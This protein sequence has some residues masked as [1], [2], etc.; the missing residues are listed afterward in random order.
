MR[1]PV[2]LL[3][4]ALSAAAALAHAASPPATFSPLSQTTL[5]QLARPAPADFDIRTGAVLAPILVPRVPGTPGSAAVQAHLMR[6]FAAHLPAW[7]VAWHNSSAPTP[8]SHGRAVPFASLIATR[9]PPWAAPADV[10]RIV[11]AAHYDSKLTPAGFVGATDSAV[12][13]ALL[14]HAARAADAALARRWARLPRGAARD[15]E[16]GVQLLLLDG[17]EAWAQWSD[18]DSLYGARALAAHWEQAHHAQPAARRNHLANIDLFVLLDLLGATAP[19]IASYFPTTHWAYAGFAA[20]EGQMREEGLFKSHQK[21]PDPWFYEG[22]AKIAASSYHGAIEDDHVPFMHRGVDILHV[23]PAPF[24]AVWHTPEDDGEHLDM[25]TVGD[26]G[27]LLTGWLIGALGLED[28]WDG[29]IA[30]RSFKTE[31]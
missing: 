10:G 4:A 14:L 1:S 3:L 29:K 6:F 5:A 30:K 31:L 9:D 16:R 17:E 15:A 19:R 23:I 22:D 27:I 18:A 25:D 28:D 2:A 13:V 26:W 11:L 24:P 7:R 21:H 20:V 8:L 12:P